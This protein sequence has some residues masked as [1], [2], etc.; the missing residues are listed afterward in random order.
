MKVA[1]ESTTSSCARPGRM[2]PPALVSDTWWVVLAGN[3]GWLWAA[4]GRALCCCLSSALP[5][6]CAC[7]RA[8]KPGRF[9]GHRPAQALLAACPAQKAEQARQPAPTFSTKMYSPVASA[10]TACVPP[11]GRSSHQSGCST[12]LP[13]PL[14][15]P[16]AAAPG[17]GRSWPGGWPCS[18]Q[19]CADAAACICC[20]DSA[21]AM[22]GCCAARRCAASC[23]ANP[24]CATLS[25]SRP[26]SCGE[27]QAF[28]GAVPL[29]AAS[30][31]A[32]ACLPAQVH[33]ATRRAQPRRRPTTTHLLC[34]CFALGR[35]PEPGLGRP[36]VPR[37]HQ[38]QR[39]P[40]DRRVVQAFR[41]AL[42]ALS[43]AH[44]VGIGLP[45]LSTCSSPA[46]AAGPQPGGRA[47]LRSLLPACSWALSCGEAQRG[48]QG[49][50]SCS[51]QHLVRV[52]VEIKAT[53][54]GLECRRVRID[55]DF[56]QGA[57]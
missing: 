32:A 33:Q 3:D 42:R 53:W 49:S 45:A 31:R 35:G 13:A 11:S 24:G 48:S 38:L 43:A 30:R 20:S 6:R 14:L 54:D 28:L 15:A 1:S 41:A 18:W 40:A 5:A 7:V 16:P 50:R 23:S 46:S 29:A 17:C 52:P 51:A 19:S 37:G 25:S 9:P 36:P 55:A 56:R 12:S 4:P 44:P 2:H 8:T 26:Y 57:T 34:A 39:L 47:P 21:V 22:R 27:G 10:T